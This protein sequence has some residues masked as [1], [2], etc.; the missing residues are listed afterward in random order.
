MKLHPNY[1]NFK[2]TLHKVPK[3]VQ[4]WWNISTL[5][6]QKVL[7]NRHQPFLSFFQTKMWIESFWNLKMEQILVNLWS[8][9]ILSLLL[10]YFTWPGGDQTKVFHCFQM[11]ALVTGWCMMGLTRCWCWWRRGMEIFLIDFLTVC[12]SDCTVWDLTKCR[13]CECIGGTFDI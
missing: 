5:T 4:L 8:I 13:D 9:A 6:W 10:Q 1:D 12:S 7:T 3:V 2:Q 11:R